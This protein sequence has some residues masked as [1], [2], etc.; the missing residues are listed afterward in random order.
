MI[1]NAQEAITAYLNASDA[2]RVHMLVRLSFDLTI[3]ARDL[4]S[5][6]DPNKRERLPGVT[7]IQHVALGQALAVSSGNAQ[8]Y[9]DEEVI[10]VLVKTAERFGLANHVQ[11]SIAQFL[12]NLQNG[13][14]APAN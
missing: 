4:T 5:S 1:R 2:E 6:A 10:R 3:T 9:P 8:K 11:H 13:A 14:G 7:E 12:G